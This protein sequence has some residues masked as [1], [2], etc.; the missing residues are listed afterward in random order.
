VIR[1]AIPLMLILAWGTQAA[2]QPWAAKMFKTKDHDFGTVARGAKSEFVFEFENIYEEDVHVASVKSSCGCTSPVITKRDLKTFEKS[3]IIAKYNTRAFLG[4]RGATVT[5]IFDKPYYAEVQLEVTGYIRSDVVFDPGSVNFGEVDQFASA[6]RTLK[7]TYA[8][9]NEWKIIDVR[10]ASKHFEVEL[11]ERQRASGRVTY[12]MM[13]RLTADAPSGYFQ[14]QL[15]IVTDDERLK[16]IPVMVHGSVV[17]PLT[18]NPASLLLGV[19]KPGQTVTKK[20]VVRGKE[21]F[22]VLRVSCKDDCFSFKVPADKTNQLHFI[23]VT[24]TADAAGKI[25]EKITIETDLGSGAVA[26][27]VASATVRE[28]AGAE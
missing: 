6:E 19:L 1:H 17:S 15:T 10:S 21:P 28:A 2:A 16:K 24:F 4:Q 8:G 14:D 26:S 3:Q 18:V 12:E 9:R 7:L 27:C 25:T 20:L 5:V 22:K 23:P 13:V 11:T